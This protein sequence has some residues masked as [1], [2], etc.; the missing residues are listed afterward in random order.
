MYLVLYVCNAFQ[1]EP[2][3]GSDAT[4]EKSSWDLMALICILFIFY[5]FFLS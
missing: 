2:K 1:E 4:A 5:S 3:P